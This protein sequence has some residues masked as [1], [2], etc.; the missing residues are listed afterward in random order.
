[1]PIAKLTSKGQITIPKSIRERFGL[2]T[3]DRV[4]FVVDPKGALIVEPVNAEGE[5]RPL[6]G[7]LQDRVRISTPVTTEE[8]DRIMKES[9]AA[10]VMASLR[11]DRK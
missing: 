5:R 4:N 8:M 9:I 6:A 1:M 2:R 10:E 3:G 11:D 7:F